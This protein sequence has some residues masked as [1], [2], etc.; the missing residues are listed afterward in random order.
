MATLDV[1]GEAVLA[2]FAVAAIVIF[3]AVIT[4]TV[5]VTA[6][7]RAEERHETLAGRAPGMWTAL[8]RRLLGAPAQGTGQVGL[9]RGI[10]RSIAA[11]RGA[12]GPDAARPGAFP[13]SPARSRA[14]TEARQPGRPSGRQPGARLA[15][16]R[17]EP[18][19]GRDPAANSAAWQPVRIRSPR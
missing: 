19:P 8:V 9:G 1:L 14:L 4:A 3:I 18:W 15:G 5:L 10:I 2:L 17:P 11:R 12:A 7:V 13:R 6:G 16:R